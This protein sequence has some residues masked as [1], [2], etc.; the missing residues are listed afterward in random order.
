MGAT[1][2][3]GLL[4]CLVAASDPSTIGADR[5]QLDTKIGGHIGCGPPLWL[6]SWLLGH[7]HIVCESL[8]VALAALGGGCRFGV[9]A[10]T[11]VYGDLPVA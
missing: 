2:A 11:C 5:S 8:S 1:G 6:R 4:S 3:F 9:F 7:S 10:F